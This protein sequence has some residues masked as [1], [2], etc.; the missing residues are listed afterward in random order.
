MALVEVPQRGFIDCGHFGQI[1]SQVLLCQILSPSTAFLA[2]FQSVLS[3][4]LRQELILNQ[5]I[6]NLANFHTQI[7]DRKPDMRH[8][9][10]KL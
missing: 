1:Q 10:M 3:S 5:C 7:L 9:P 2:R 6:Q 4:R 8:L